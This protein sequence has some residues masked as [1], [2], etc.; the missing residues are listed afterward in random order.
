MFHMLSC[1]DLKPGEDID[2]FRNAYDDFAACMKSR[3]CLSETGLRSMRPT[4]IS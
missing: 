1:F 3:S 4:P 2:T